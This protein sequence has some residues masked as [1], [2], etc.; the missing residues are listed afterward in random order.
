MTSNVLR[1][2]GFNRANNAAMGCV[3]AN[4]YTPAWLAQQFYERRWRSLTIT[5]NDSRDEVGGITDTD[6][7]KRTWWGECV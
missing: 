4:E 5:R 7:G 6:D 2:R 1:Y 3:D